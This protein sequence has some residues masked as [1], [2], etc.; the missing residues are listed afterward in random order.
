MAV[1]GDRSARDRFI[2]PHALFLGVA[3]S[4]AACCLAGRLGS[5]HNL[6]EHFVRFHGPINPSTYFYPT[7]SQVRALALSRLDPEKVAVVIGGNSI[8]YG[9]G[10]S[11][12]EVWTRELQDRLGDGFCVLNLA[13]WGSAP[14]EFGAVAAEAIAPDRPR[15]V[16]VTIA[17]PPAW[18]CVPDGVN[19]PYFYWD[20]FHQ[21]LLLPDPGRAEVVARLPAERAGCNPPGEMPTKALLNSVCYF[22]D[23]WTGVN[24]SYAGT[25]WNRPLA[26]KWYRPRSGMR[27]ADVSAPDLAHRYRPELLDAEMNVV[28]ARFGYGGCRKDGEGRWVENL[29]APTWTDLQ[30]SARKCF[31]EACRKRTLMVVQA[32]S[33]YYVDRL[34]ADERAHYAALSRLTAE[35][36]RGVGFAAAEM[37]DGFTAEDFADRCHLAPSGGSKLAGKVAGAVRQL[38]ADLGYTH[39]PEP[40]H[41]GR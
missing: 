32:E 35:K 16:L 13:L 38:A 7:A 30:E 14:H 12:S 11:E 22:D 26:D 15:L 28:R 25:V 39:A 31:P 4:F 2:R 40:G 9:V 10:Q 36:L 33:P 23:L 8:L 3:C 6:F 17:A 24:Y 29:S 27:D 19:H 20:A 1:P 41:E 5:R 37:G 21:G 34:T 18:P